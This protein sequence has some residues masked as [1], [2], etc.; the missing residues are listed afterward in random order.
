MRVAVF[1][2][3][4]FVGRH[5][6]AKLAS[7][8]H[9]VR[10]VARRSAPSA[11]V[12]AISLD[13]AGAD[14]ARLA[15]AVRG[16]DAV[17]NLVG[18]KRETGEQT[19]KN[20]H[21]AFVERLAQAMRDEGVKRLVHVSVV[22]ARPDAKSGYHDT[23][24]QAEERIA[25]AGLD[26]TIL[27][28]GVIYGDG[29]DLLAHLTKMI[30]AS[31]VFPIAGKGLT[32]QQP[33]DVADVAAA[34]A[35]CLAKPATF[36]KTY[37]IVG[38]EPLTLR[39][40][41]GR[42]ARALG[43]ET[44]IVGTPIALMRPA[45]HVMN[46]VMENPLSTPAQLQMLEDGMTG[47]PGAMRR[48]LGVDPL[49]FTVD[50]IRAPAVGSPQRLP[51]ALRL[52]RREDGEL[53][54]ESGSRLAVLSIAGIV[55]MNAAFLVSAAD[56]WIRLV[57][58]IALLGAV[59]LPTAWRERRRLFRVDALG[60]AVGLATGL[61]LYGIARALAA[62]PAMAEQVARVAAWREGHSEGF[63]FVTLVVAVVSEELF[64]RGEI[65]RA[66]AT[67][68]PR[69]I[70]ALAG[71]AIFSVA[72]VASGTWLLPGAAAGIVLV[73][74]LLFLVTDSL[75]APLASHLVFDLLA[76]LVAPLG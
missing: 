14:V 59:A 41:V 17:V 52:G 67:R 19:F 60:V 57:S 4:G 21:V 20:L 76:M 30:R 55:V 40:I 56:P 46:R 58:G 66:L 75:V 37:V 25:K 44:R 2:A 36:G 11:N 64:W 5:V 51:F 29:D 71:T 12:T 45:V 62:V 70:A 63:V 9:E 74:N 24:W 10:A 16:C 61:A 38:P 69:W 7:E 28:P 43:L 26:A 23:K 3:S 34:V 53:G 73:W 50:R 47:D 48:D 39:E 68:A 8:G 54:A 13:V 22:A 49:P 35:A 31:P 27:R 72:H 32:E 1:G 15:E 65:T 33:V 18:I 42:V 6:V